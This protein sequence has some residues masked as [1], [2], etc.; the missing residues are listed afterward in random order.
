MCI[1]INKILIF[2]HIAMKITDKVTY[3]AKNNIIISFPRTNIVAFFLASIIQQKTFK[4][5]LLIC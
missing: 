1:L 3:F 2:R 5:L 4:L